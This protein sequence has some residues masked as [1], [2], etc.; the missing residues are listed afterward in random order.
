[1]YMY[2]LTP[3][4]PGRLCRALRDGVQLFLFFMHEVAFL[5]MADPVGIREGTH[6]IGGELVLSQAADLQASLKS[7]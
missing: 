6:A 1:M 3:S 4:I 7:G 2:V 5:N